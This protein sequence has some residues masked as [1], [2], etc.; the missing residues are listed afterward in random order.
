MSIGL[1]VLFGLASA[2][3]WGTGDF[4][5]GIASK[6][7]NVYYVVL[8]AHIIS[9]LLLILAGLIIEPIP[10]WSTL[11]VGGLGGIV[12]AI[13]LISLYKGLAVGKMSV[14]APLAAVITVI[15]PVIYSYI[16]EG[17]LGSLQQI[18]ILLALFSIIFISYNNDEE[19][20]RTQFIYPVVAG[21]CFGLFFIILS[22]AGESSVLWTLVAA[23]SSS[24]LLLGLLV[25]FTLSE[26]LPSKNTF[27]IIAIA[28]I[29][30][31]LGNIFFI[32]ASQQGRLDLA[33]ILS[34]F[35]PATT[36][37]LARI[38]QKELISTIQKMGVIFSLLAIVLIST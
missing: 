19:K 7:S 15:L 20:G 36:V 2:I 28:G 26:K 38:I 9:L 27:L 13:G 30:D 6:K 14:I 12:G 10:S 3:T 22:F 24:V 21:I 8:F 11:F 33:S 29:F 5:G 4:S 18:G 1:V 23:R 17:A 25:N 32:L 35:Y 31:T 16:N 34:S 37:I